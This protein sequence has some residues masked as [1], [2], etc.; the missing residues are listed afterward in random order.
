[1]GLVA[2][3]LETGCS[4]ASVRSEING[5]LAGACRRA[6]LRSRFPFLRDFGAGENR[7]GLTPF[8]LRLE[9]V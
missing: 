9:R 6:A 7:S 8:Y 5:D 4:F 3:A 2:A 1:M